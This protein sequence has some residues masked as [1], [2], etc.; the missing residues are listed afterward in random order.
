M[1][2]A[3]LRYAAVFLATA[4][5]VAV[6]TRLANTNLDGTFGSGI[7]IVIPA[8]IAAVVEG[9]QFVKTARRK[10]TMAE[11]WG[12]SWAATV[13]ATALMVGL[14]YLA[15]GLAPEFGKLAGPSLISQQ[16]LI[17]LVIYGTAYLISNRVFLGISASN[18]VSILRN[19]GLIK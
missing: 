14:A 5:G 11:A 16:F 1:V 2:V 13:V 18:Q 9:G 7:Q 8:M 10:P 6:L 15:G 4:L 12:F 3:L 19:K 17:T